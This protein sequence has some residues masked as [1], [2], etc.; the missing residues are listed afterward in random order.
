M[1]GARLIVIYPRPKDIES[2]ERVYLNE[3]VH[4][5]RKAR[6]QEQ[7]CSEQD[8][9]FP[10][11]NATVPSYCRDPFPNNEGS[12]G[13]RRIG[14]R[15]TDNRQCGGDFFRGRTDLPGLGR[16]SICVLADQP[17]MTAVMITRA[18]R[19]CLVIHS[20]V[21][22]ISLRAQFSRVSVQESQ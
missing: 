15:Q 12:G 3:H 11:R 13:V 21:G 7:D 2:F 9:W 18:D 5:R 14:R 16:G 17:R 10:T 20:L 19:K 4:G 22:N 6:R 8:S 1:A